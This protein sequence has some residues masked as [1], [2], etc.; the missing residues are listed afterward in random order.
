MEHAI[1]VE[2]LCVHTG[3]LIHCVMCY[4][5]TSAAQHTHSVHTVP[6]SLQ[7]SLYVLFPVNGYWRINNNILRVLWSLMRIFA[8]GNLPLRQLY[9]SSLALQLCLLCK[10]VHT[11]RS[12]SIPARYASFL[13]VQVAF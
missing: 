11:E 2:S 9:P 7:I 3:E 8:R 6:A 1:K 4:Y 10:H 12:I 5:V 13:S